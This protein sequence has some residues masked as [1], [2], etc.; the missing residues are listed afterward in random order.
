MPQGAQSVSSQQ[1]QSSQASE[2]M[3][4]PGELESVRVRRCG[5][6]FVS[7]GG[8]GVRRFYIPAA[9]LFSL[10]VCACGRPVYFACRSL[11]DAWTL[12]LRCSN[13]ELF[14][15]RPPLSVSLLGCCFLCS[16]FSVLSFSGS[17]SVIRYVLTR[18]GGCHAFLFRPSLCCFFSV[19][20]S[21]R[22]AGLG[23]SHNH[24]TKLFL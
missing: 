9:L 4:G 23:R 18:I 20:F 14:L 15:P 24:V 1:H 19:P 5:T 21:R 13:G 3:P 16:Q 7:C 6:F 12:T 10:C 11:H 17:P 22:P 2:Q 8:W